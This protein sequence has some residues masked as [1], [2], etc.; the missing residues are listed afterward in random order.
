MTGAPRDDGP[1]TQPPTGLGGSGRA[2]FDSLSFESEP[3]ACPLW[4]VDASEPDVFVY[5]Y[6][7][8]LSRVGL[9]VPTR[10]PP[11]TGASLDLLLSHR[12]GS[13]LLLQ[14]CVQWVNPW[15]PEGDNVNPGMGI[16]LSR[17]DADLRERLVEAVPTLAYLR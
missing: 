7:A 13:P 10:Q 11:C 2:S 5:V 14:G 4:A 17:L 15:R 9:F 8:D 3:C 12:T 16:L 1:P 6:L